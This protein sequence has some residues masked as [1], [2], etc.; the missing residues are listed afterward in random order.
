M[1]GHVTGMLTAT[2]CKSQ[3]QHKSVNLFFTITNIK[4]TLM[5]SYGNGL[6]KNDCINLFCNISPCRRALPLLLAPPR[7]LVVTRFG[8]ASSLLPSLPGGTNPKPK[9]Q[10]PKPK[11][12]IL[13]PKIQNSK[14]SSLTTKLNTKFETLN[15]VSR[16]RNPQP[17]TPKPQTGSG[18]PGFSH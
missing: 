15:A 11:I 2:F 7:A 9:T 10:N 4:N 3:C 18:K 1:Y 12:Q 5:N 8:Q 6:L 14:L 13:K 17:K 16:L